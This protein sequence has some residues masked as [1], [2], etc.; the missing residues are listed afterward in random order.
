MTT[1]NIKELVAR[2]DEVSRILQFIYA[3][4][5][6]ENEAVTAELQARYKVL[7]EQLTEKDKTILKKRG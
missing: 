5:N 3:Q 2:Q 7:D 1:K 6:E 4:P